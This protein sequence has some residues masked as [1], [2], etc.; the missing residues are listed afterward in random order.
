MSPLRRRETATDDQARTN[1]L[2][3]A[4]DTTTGPLDECDDVILSA[5]G[6]EVDGT[7]YPPPGHGY[8]RR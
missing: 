3:D 7:P 4:I 2:L 6:A 1:R 5:A 8:P